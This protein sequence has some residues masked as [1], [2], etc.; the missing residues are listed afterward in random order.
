MKK[1]QSVSS[2]KIAVAKANAAWQK[3]EAAEKKAWRALRK[4]EQSESADSYWKID[5]ARKAHRKA[6][7]AEYAAHIAFE[8]AQ[9]ALVRKVLKQLPAQMAQD[10]FAAWNY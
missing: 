5:D 4:A 9:A 1:V 7:D 3:A 10:V 8:R 2:L 6:N